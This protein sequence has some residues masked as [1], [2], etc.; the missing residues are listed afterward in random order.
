MEEAKNLLLQTDN[1]VA[2]IAEALGYCSSAY[3]I[4]EFKKVFSITPK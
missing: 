3:F 2:D 4:W 1:K